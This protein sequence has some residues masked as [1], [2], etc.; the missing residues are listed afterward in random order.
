LERTATPCPLGNLAP[1]FFLEALASA[2]LKSRWILLGEHLW[3]GV[4]V[5][6]PPDFSGKVL[7]KTLT[8]CGLNGGEEVT[9]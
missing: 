6:L 2:L 7:C 8:P 3:E 5:E 1:C 9:V 4:E